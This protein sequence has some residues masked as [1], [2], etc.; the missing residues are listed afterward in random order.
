MNRIV[1]GQDAD[2]DLQHREQRPGDA[3]VL[4]EAE[5]RVVREAL[6]RVDAEQRLVVARARLVHRERGERDRGQREVDDEDGDRDEPDRAGDRAQRVARLLGEVRDGLDPGVGDHPDRDRE[7]EV[8][9]G[10]RDP[11]VDVL[12]QD[13][14]AEDEDEADQHE[15]HLRREVDHR[16]QDV[17]LRRLLDPDDVQ[18]DQE[19]DHDR[20]A[21]DVPRVLPQ[22][23]PEDR[24]VVRH[25]ER[26]DGDRDHVV[27]HLGPRGPERDELVERVAREARRAARLR[28]ADGALG[29]GRGGHREDDAR[30]HEH[31]W[32]QPEREARR[33][34]ERVVDRG[35]DVAVRGGEERGRAEDAL[36]AVLLP[37]ATR[38]RGSLCPARDDYSGHAPTGRV[39]GQSP[40]MSPAAMAI[41]AMYGD[42]PRTWRGWTRPLR[43]RP[44]DCPRVM[45]VPAMT[46]RAGSL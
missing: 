23:A 18:R 34:A 31:E 46:R 5:H 25:E 7:E 44:G 20:A 13:V 26:R 35:A 38:H 39:R 17:Q 40:V 3:E 42:C 33:D 11:E 28:I 21:D 14:R 30:D 29:V 2:V 22:R 12:L 8:P 9:P 6:R 24:E 32:G 1:A 36:E 15:Q 43:P 19:H 27:Q 45:A 10:R 37:P 16:E 41:R 4:D